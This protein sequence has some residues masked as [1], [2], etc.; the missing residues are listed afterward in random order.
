M[1]HFY[2]GLFVILTL[3]VLGYYTLFMADVALFSSRSEVQVLFPDAGGLREGDSVLLAGRRTGRVL[4]LVYD[5]NAPEEQRIVATLSIEEDVRL[6]KDYSIVI[7]EATA[8]GGHRVD[9]EPGTPGSPEIGLDQ[10][11]RGTVAPGLFSAF[12]GLGDALGGD[13]GVS[14][15]VAKL[16]AIVD[17][18]QEGGAAG[19]LSKTL[20]NFE[21]ASGDVAELTRKLSAG[22]GTLGAMFATREFYDAWLGTGKDV[23]AAATELQGLVSDARTGDGI[24]AAALNDAELK[25]QAKSLVSDASATFSDISEITSGVREGKGLVGKIFTDEATAESGGNLVANLEKVS[26]DLVD[27]KGTMGRL[28]QSDE[29]YVNANNTFADLSKVTKGLADGEGTLGMLLV[30]DEI[31]KELKLAVKTLTRSLEDYREAAPISTLT[32]VLFSA[33]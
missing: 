3:F 26:K 15:L 8:L 2:V 16:N 11:L 19:N 10:P 25:D 7:K 30:D 21:A 4:R 33:F 1:R 14:E 27:G 32:S 29:L 13:E 9:V 31:G 20:S 5:P 12:Q 17:E 24:V 28:F 6:R 18:L 22:E 23:D